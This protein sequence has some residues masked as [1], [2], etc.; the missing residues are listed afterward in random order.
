MSRIK[1]LPRIAADMLKNSCVRSLELTRHSEKQ[2]EYVHVTQDDAGKITVVT[3][4]KQ[5]PEVTEMSHSVHHQNGLPFRGTVPLWDGSDIEF[6]GSEEA[7]L[8]L[9]AY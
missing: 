6:Y 8:R 9:L 1:G 7:Y 5:S 4:T 2:D 3:H